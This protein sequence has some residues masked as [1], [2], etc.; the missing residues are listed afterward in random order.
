MGV[1][2]APSPGIAAVVVSYNTRALLDRC[3]ASL[4]TA[5][6]VAS[7]SGETWV[8]DN[9]SSDGS[10]R[11]VAEHHPSVRLVDAGANLGYAGGA[12]RALRELV[13]RAVP[14]WAVAVM[15]PDTEA[16]PDALARLVEALAG[17][18]G[19]AIAGPSLQYPDGRFQHGA[20]RF[21]GVVQ[22]VLDLWPVERLADSRLNGRYARARY[23][24]G[25]PF[26]IDFPLG[27]CMLVRTDAA[28]SVGLLDEGY[29]MY[30]EEIDW[31]RRFRDAGW[32][33]LCAPAAV[34]V[35]HAGASTSEQRAAMLGAL[36]RSRLRYFGL[37]E[38]RGRA[39]CLR[40]LVRV[41]LAWRA[42]ADR[43]DERRGRL[44]PD[45]RR[46]R[47][48]ALRA[49]VAATSPTGPDRRGA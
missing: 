29:F 17:D 28:R 42:A 39:A 15:N 14:P 45:E 30:C 24:G 37:H 3:L 48:A 6:A 47:R 2:P 32:R 43:V 44:T 46:A 20:F 49:A 5:M 34:V 35:H 40:T 13:S 26:E 12:N 25:R 9:G 21:P 18:P 38:P 23:A 10:A 19:A 22:T 1:P 7:P 4:R 31:C 16:R 27:A 11:M 41:G 8:V 33:A 36:W